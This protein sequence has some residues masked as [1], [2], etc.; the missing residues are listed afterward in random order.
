MYYCNMCVAT[1]C[2][3]CCNVLNFEIK[4][5]FLIRPFTYMAKKPREKPKYLENKK[6]FKGEIKTFFIIFKGLSE[7]KNCPRP[8]SAPLTHSLID[9]SCC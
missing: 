2:F 3:P 8:D 9:V 5:M 6:S 1:V 7:T 4:L